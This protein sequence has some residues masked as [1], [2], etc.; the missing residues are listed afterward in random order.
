VMTSAGKVYVPEPPN[1]PG[2]VLIWPV[3]PLYEMT[4]VP[5]SELEEILLLKVLK[6]VSERY[7]FAATPD[8]VIVMAF[9]VRM[10][11]AVNVR[12]FSKSV[13]A[14]AATTLPPVE[15]LRIDPSPRPVTARLVVVALVKLASTKCEVDE[16]KIPLCAHIVELVAAVVT[17]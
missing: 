16:A 9:T 6:S 15:I 5:E 11:G 17:P 8:C 4:D 2:V 14:V 1:V 12:A 10:S 13:P 7:P 3:E